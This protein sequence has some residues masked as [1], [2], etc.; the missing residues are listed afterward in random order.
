MPFIC[1]SVEVALA[2]GEQEILPGISVTTVSGHTPYQQLLEVETQYGKTVFVSDLFPM[3]AHGP[4]PYVMSYDIEPLKTT[5]EKKKL[6]ERA[7]AE[8]L[9]FWFYHDPDHHLGRAV[10]N[11]NR[12]ALEAL[13]N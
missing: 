1:G 4:L 12:Y 8:D 5:S 6:L 11:G 13:V 3:K 7:I 2:D 9:V 10:K